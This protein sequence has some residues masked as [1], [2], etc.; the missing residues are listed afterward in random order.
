MADTWLSLIAEGELC[1]AEYLTLLLLLS[2]I[3][4]SRVGRN[5]LV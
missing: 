2:K 5:P 3:S 1:T 4:M